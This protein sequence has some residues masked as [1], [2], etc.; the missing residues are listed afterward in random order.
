MIENYFDMGPLTDYY[1][2]IG[3]KRAGPG[4]EF[5]LANGDAL[6]Q[7]AS[8][9]PSYAHWSWFHVIAN[10]TA[11]YDCVIAQQAFRYE[12]FNGNG[13]D[14]RQLADSR[15]YNTDARNTERAFGWN[16]YPCAAK[17]HFVCEVPASAFPCFPPP[18]PPLAPGAPPPPPSPP[19]PAAGSG[20]GA[21]SN[22]CECLLLR[23]RLAAWH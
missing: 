3:A 15:F 9:A 4:S 20:A 16:A 18:P 7:G 21:G 14:L 2:W 6:R 19:R 10:G 1:Y 5:Q 17:L 11:N 13:S 22:D 8:N 12:Q 23:S